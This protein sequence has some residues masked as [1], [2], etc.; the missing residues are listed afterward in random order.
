MRAG[1]VFYKNVYCGRIEQD[2]DGTFRFTYDETYLMREDAEAVS[3]TLSLRKESYESN[4][5]FPFFDGLI[6][7][8]WLLDISTENWKLDPHDR[9]GL[10]LKVCHD[11]IGAASVEEIVDE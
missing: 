5:L 10:L 11:P 4:V 3:L 1:K 9:M 7:E 8:G 6:P 2:D